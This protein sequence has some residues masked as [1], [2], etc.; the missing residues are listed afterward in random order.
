MPTF[1]L[2]YELWRLTHDDVNLTFVKKIRNAA[3]AA[4]ATA[5]A[6]AEEE[7]TEFQN[8]EERDAYGGW[9]TYETHT[10]AIADLRSVRVKQTDDCIDIDTMLR[11]TQVQ[12]FVDTVMVSG[13]GSGRKSE[14]IFTDAISDDEEHTIRPFWEEQVVLSC[15]AEVPAIIRGLIKD[16]GL[17]AA[18]TA[19][20]A[21]T[22]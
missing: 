12:I 20:T 11:C 18:V 14:C 2:D 1:L 3:A 6:D 5:A 4:E 7:P 19:V 13:S 21:V 10:F 15:I 8:E 17:V 22:A 16:S 9:Y